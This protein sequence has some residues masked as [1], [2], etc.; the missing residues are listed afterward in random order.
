MKRKLT[1]HSPLVP[2]QYSKKKLSKAT[3]V[4]IYR[5]CVLLS[6]GTW[7]DS[8][9]NA[10]VFYHRDELRKGSIQWESKYLNL[11]HDY[12]V[13]KRLG[14]VENPYYENG[15]V[16]GDLYIFPVTQAAKDTIALIDAGLVNWLSVEM[17]TY[18]RWDY[19][20]NKIFAEDIRFIGAAIVLYG[21]CPDS[22]ILP[23][24]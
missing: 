17:K 3:D 12:S 10:P 24:K 6:E 20:E 14:F 4:R 18:D 23:E 9:T 13:L 2:F 22:R 1:I 8:I 7:S 15:K 11:D 5:D 21:A 16:L 19:S